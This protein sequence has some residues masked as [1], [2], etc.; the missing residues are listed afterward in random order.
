MFS[1]VVGR[2]KVKL[3][4]LVERSLAS[5]MNSPELCIFSIRFSKTYRLGISVTRM[6]SDRRLPLPRQLV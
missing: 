5:F 2:P 3:P 6:V 1:K 4:N